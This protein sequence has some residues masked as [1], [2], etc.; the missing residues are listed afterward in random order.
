[1]IRQNKPIC[2]G[3][4]RFRENK[5]R[6]GGLRLQGQAVLFFMTVVVFLLCGCGKTVSEEDG[7]DS[8]VTAVDA[9]AAEENTDQEEA[10]VREK[11]IDLGEEQQVGY[12]RLL[13]S[14]PSGAGYELDRSV[15]GEE[16]F[17]FYFSDNAAYL[18]EE[19]ISFEA[20][21]MRYIRVMIRGNGELLRLESYEEDPWQEIFSGLN[22][23]IAEGEKGEYSVMLS[24]LPDDVDAQFGGCNLEQIIDSEGRVTLPLQEKEVQVGYRLTRGDWAVDTPDLSLTV[25]SGYG[26]VYD[27]TAVGTAETNECPAVIPSLQEWRGG[28]GE[29]F[30]TKDS[31]IL[32]NDESL[33]ETAAQLKE[34]LQDLTGW[35][36][37]AEEAEEN[38]EIPAGDILLEL[39]DAVFPAEILLPGGGSSLGEEGY[40]MEADSTVR[41]Q[42]DTQRGV[43][44]GTRTLL[45]LVAL[46]TEQGER[47]QNES[48]QEETAGT[49]EKISI[50]RGWIRDY[51]ESPVRGIEVDVARN[52]A[53]VYFLE[54]LARNMSWYKL[55]ELTL[56]LND[57]ALLAYVEDKETTEQALEAYSAYRMES[58]LTGSSGK[59]YTAE[60]FYYTS[61]AFR[62]LVDAAGKWGVEIIP[63]IDTP[64][65]SMAFTSA[66]PELALT[67]STESV[68][69]LD[70]SKPEASELALQ[71][72]EEQLSDAFADCS[73]L[74][75][76]ADEYFG[77]SD[78]YLEYIDGLIRTLQPEGKQLRMWGSLSSIR[79]SRKIDPGTGI[80]LCIWNTSWADP[81]MMYRA[82]F[83]LINTSSDQLYL[84]PAGGHDYLDKQEMLENFRVNRYL[85]ED[86]GE[87]LL[88][89]WSEQIRGAVVV[90]WND[91]CGD[92]DA[93]ISEYDMMDRLLDI[94]PAFS[95]K[96]WNSESG[97][98]TEEFEQTARDLGTAPGTDPFDRCLSGDSM[99]LGPDYE[100]TFTVCLSADEGGKTSEGNIPEEQIL[101][102]TERSGNIYSFKAVQKETGKVGFSGEGRDYSFDYELPEGESVKLT[103][104]GEKDRTTLFVNGEE[105]SALG[106]SDTFSMHATFLF[107][108][109]RYGGSEKIF[110]GTISE[111]E[112]LNY[113][114]NAD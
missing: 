38:D 45:Q 6:R 8:Q 49:A 29:L 51:P 59:A 83:D 39:T 70:L 73:T 109:E 2:A 4:Q 30:L 50:V 100:V 75:I 40:C 22:V 103:V 13:W 111:V 92:L 37:T 14:E 87:L 56:H 16:Y 61:E 41:I 32:Y 69:Q 84:I 106:S 77:I 27:E 82:G 18:E 65:H 102:Q 112:I 11:I 71:L 81:Q 99:L 91:L 24:G 62:E 1:M 42:A 15:D 60:D 95:E 23:S 94:A 85:K 34:E 52:T 63:E 9:G 47:D 66:S 104:R 76:G 10:A 54:Q 55:N 67:Y 57:N 19:T 107:P 72:W 110:H 3:Q 33:S 74:H 58:S 90:L 26:I 97:R 7:S 48:G 64:A 21:P 31:R 68:D 114:E 113:Q 5:K 78:Q 17:P 98:R 101:F 12:V 108:L 43:Y 20:L 105:V 80:E 93:G 53:S 44:W 96:T 89:S 36:L 86:G 25:P 79:G 88:P 35:A 46:N 28:Q